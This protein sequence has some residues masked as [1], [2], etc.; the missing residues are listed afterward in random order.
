MKETER[1]IEKEAVTAVL[2]EKVSPLLRS[3]GGDLTLTGIFRSVVRVSF[4]GACRYCP[5]ACETLEHVVQ[6]ILREAL[7]YET[8]RVETDYGVSQALLDEAKRILRKTHE[9]N[10]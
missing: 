2:R 8:I 6:K 10:L 7:S 4:T 3:H 9:S 1:F 5:S